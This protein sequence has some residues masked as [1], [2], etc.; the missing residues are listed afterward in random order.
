MESPDSV[1]VVLCDDAHDAELSLPCSKEVYR[2]RKV[3]GYRYVTVQNHEDGRRQVR[4]VD[5]ESD[6][7]VC[8]MVY[9]HSDGT[10]AFVFK[11]GDP[12]C[13]VELLLDLRGLCRSEGMRYRVAHSR[14]LLEAAVAQAVRYSPARVEKAM[15]EVGIDSVPLKR[16][17]VP[18]CLCSVLKHPKY[19]C[20]PQRAKLHTDC[21]KGMDGVDRRRLL[22]RFDA[23]HVRLE[24]RDLV[25]NGIHCIPPILLVFPELHFV[26]TDRGG[27]EK[28]AIS[29]PLTSFVMAGTAPGDAVVPAKIRE[30]EEEQSDESTVHSPVM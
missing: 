16:H 3:P 17:P 28:C 20:T 14:D 27:A 22:G 8:Y 1:G 2:V 7:P 13:R 26:V 6:S 11:L 10:D 23:V 19:F 18:K 4:R 29:R 9:G 30:L 25:E 5:P 15:R 21:V 12:E 24:A